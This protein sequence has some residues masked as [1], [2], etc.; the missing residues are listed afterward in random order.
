MPCSVKAKGGFRR[1]I[2]AVGLDITICDFQSSSS[3]LVSWN[4]KSAGKRERLR[5]TAWLRALV[6]T[7]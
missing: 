3:T 6:G 4:M 2:R 1:P 7:P 5:R